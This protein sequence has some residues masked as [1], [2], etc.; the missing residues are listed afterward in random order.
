MDPV[1]QLK[2]KY[3][4][5]DN[6]PL[7]LGIKILDLKPGLAQVSLKVEE[8]M[9]NF[10]Q[11]AHGG[12][13]FT[14]ADTAFGLASNLRGQAVALQVSTNFLKPATAGNILTATARE[15]YL[16]RK[17]GIYEV[18]IENEKNETLFLFRGTAYRKANGSTG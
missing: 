5:Q 8:S 6:F 3:Y 11:I 10:H 15:L 7:R 1:E 16:T 18:V 14:L 17:T 13:L 4:N 2:Q 12:V 9:T